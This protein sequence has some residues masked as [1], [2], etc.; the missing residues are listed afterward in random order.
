MQKAWL[1]GAAALLAVG[2]AVLFMTERPLTVT[3]VRP[4]TGVALR[5]YGLG[6]VEARVLARV[7]FEV[8]ATLMSLS[9]DAGDTVVQGQELEAVGVFELIEGHRVYLCHR[10]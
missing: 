5:I 8:G 7:G 10:W 6:T 9:A 2:A 1:I 3:V 4:E